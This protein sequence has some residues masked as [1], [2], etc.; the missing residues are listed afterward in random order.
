M[1]D[2]IVDR[3][4]SIKE[5]KNVSPDGHEFLDEK[6]PLSA[7]HNGS[8][9]PTLRDILMKIQDTVKET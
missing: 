3:K 9:R 1:A 4:S 6:G 7:Q 5:F 2:K 8:N